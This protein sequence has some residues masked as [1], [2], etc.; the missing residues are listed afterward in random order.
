MTVLLPCASA[1]DPCLDHLAVLVQE[2]HLLGG[3]ALDQSLVKV[4]LGTEL[5]LPPEPADNDHV[6][7]S[8][9]TRFLG[10]LGCGK[11]DDEEPETVYVP[12]ATR[13]GLM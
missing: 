6:G 1:F 9:D 2:V 12:F 7:R 13:D 10:K 5:G 11:V 4:L 8:L 3:D